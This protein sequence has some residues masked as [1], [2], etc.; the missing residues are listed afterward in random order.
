MMNRFLSEASE[1]VS[2]FICISINDFQRYGQEVLGARYHV[3]QALQAT[4]DGWV[5]VKSSDKAE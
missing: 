3:N 2:G 1:V 5:I 4:Q